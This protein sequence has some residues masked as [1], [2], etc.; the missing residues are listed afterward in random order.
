MI[1]RSWAD[2]CP[3]RWQES[4][5]AP[6]LGR[7]PIQCPTNQ[8]DLDPLPHSG[9]GSSVH[10]PC[11]C[12]DLVPLLPRDSRTSADSP[13]S[14]ADVGGARVLIQK[15]ENLNPRCIFLPCVAVLPL[16]KV[17]NPTCFLCIYS[18][19]KLHYVPLMRGKGLT[20][21]KM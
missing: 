8:Y 6:Q 18:W 20:S 21:W 15:R 7:T 5:L 14:S 17:L 1:P 9:A 16:I 10:C 11:G 2:P 13:G 4:V 12:E 3:S 19:D